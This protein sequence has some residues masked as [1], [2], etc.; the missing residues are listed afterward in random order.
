MSGPPKTHSFLNRLRGIKKPVNWEQKQSLPRYQQGMSFLS[1]GASS[2]LRKTGLKSSSKYFNNSRKR[3]EF[4][5]EQRQSYALLD[6]WLK[7]LGK[8]LKNKMTIFR[9]RDFKTL[10]HLLKTIY[11]KNADEKI[12]QIKK[13][14][15][16]QKQKAN[17]LIVGDN[18]NLQRL[19][20]MSLNQFKIEY[21]PQT[22]LQNLKTARITIDK[23]DNRIISKIVNINEKSRRIKNK[24]D[25]LTY[26]SSLINGKINGATTNNNKVSK[27]LYMK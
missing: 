2:A 11:D 27:I 13:F 8:D 4:S 22:S 17:N 26:L 10:E 24:Y 14:R 1:S 23:L 7:D 25:K 19:S 12:K 9:G 15:D 18:K 16:K 21:P 5:S 20:S 3:R 6:S